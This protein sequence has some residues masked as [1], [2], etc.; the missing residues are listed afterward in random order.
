MSWYSEMRHTISSQPLRWKI[1]FGRENLYEDQTM[2]KRVLLLHTGGTLGMAGETPRPSSTGEPVGILG[3]SSSAINTLLQRIPELSDIAELRIEILARQDSCDIRASQWL[4]W[5]ERIRQETWA[6]GIVL[7]HGT[8][9]MVYTAS[10]LS[11]L[12]EERERPIILTGSQRP[13]SAVRTDARQNLV[14]ATILACGPLREVTLC[15]DSLGLRGNRALKRSSAA[16]GAF[17]SPN[18][19]PLATLGVDIHYANHSLSAAGTPRAL[20]LSDHVRLTWVMPDLPAPEPWRVERPAVHIL[21]AFGSGNFPLQTGWQA[22]LDAERKA[23]ITHLV[24]SQCPHGSVIPGLYLTSQAV[25]ERDAISGGDMSY[26]AA[27]AK[28]RVGLGQ[29]LEGPALRHYLESNIAGER[30]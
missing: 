25:F 16:M 5:A 29:K 11:F 20:A 12:L 27:I 4:T 22:L 9:T 17:D 2:K 10:I 14:D 28:A 18:C 6:D 21:A 24:V 3:P 13:L 23:G 26:V 30:S 1:P 19:P 7:I 8:D 15:F